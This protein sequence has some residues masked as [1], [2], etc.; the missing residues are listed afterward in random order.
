VSLV[1]T[2][3][4]LVLGLAILAAA[5]SSFVSNRAVFRQTE[6]IARLQETARVATLLLES[7]IRQAGGSLCRKGLPLTNLVNS[8]AW[9]AQP[10]QGIEG[11]DSATSDSRAIK[12]GTAD[13][14]DGTDSITIWSANSLPRTQVKAVP[15]NTTT[16][17][18][19]TFGVDTHTRLGN[20]SL[21]VVCDYS[22]AAM[23]QVT[24][25]SGNNIVMSTTGG[26]PGNCRGA[27]GASASGASLTCSTITDANQ[28]AY[29]FGTSVELGQL[30]AHHWYVGQKTTTTTGSLNNLALRRMTLSNTAGATTASASSEEILENVSD[31]QITYLIG[32]ANGYPN[33]TSYVAAT[34][35]SDWTK[36]IAVR[37]V[38]TVKSTEAIA[39]DGSGN[40]SAASIQVPID[41]TI[42]SRAPRDG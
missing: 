42:R 37:I 6:G 15:A 22:R 36:V 41:I 27:L 13:R 12:T 1:E 16:S 2:M 23:F 39:H 7:D 14:F 31:M 11:F 9:W 4:S 10:A 8:T 32:N 24:G 34:D 21:A 3:V 18:S 30:S 25:S 17:P 20:G 38:L 28:G 26:T 19:N 33:T 40:G 29:N 35:I 5:F